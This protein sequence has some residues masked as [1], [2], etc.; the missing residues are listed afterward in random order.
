[1]ATDVMSASDD[2]Y[3]RQQVFAACIK[4]LK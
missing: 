1:M 3:D 4:A 2:N